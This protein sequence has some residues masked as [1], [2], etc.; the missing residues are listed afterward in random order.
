MRR[1]RIGGGFYNYYASTKTS[2]GRRCLWCEGSRMETRLVCQGEI[3]EVIEKRCSI[4]GGT[5]RVR[6]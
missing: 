3:P 2:K 5:G 4:C 1:T 6:L